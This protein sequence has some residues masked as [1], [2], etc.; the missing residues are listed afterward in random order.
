MTS[1][2]IQGTPVTSAHKGEEVI[3]VPS[4]ANGDVQHQDC[5]RGEIT[6]FNGV[7]VFVRYGDDD[8]SK[9]TRYDDLVWA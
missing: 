8:T 6:S 1:P 5:E 2:M 3:Y 4:H 9:A 7:H